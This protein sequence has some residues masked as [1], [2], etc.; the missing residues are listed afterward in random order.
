MM[1][2]TPKLL[3]D[4]T[5]PVN[6]PCPPIPQIALLSMMDPRLG[7]IAAILTPPTT[8]WCL[9]RDP[10]GNADLTFQATA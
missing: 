10:L 4:R 2:Q 6:E 7:S 9:M 1:A 3:T 8:A 5:H